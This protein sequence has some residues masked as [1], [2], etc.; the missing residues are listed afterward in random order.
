MFC[1]Q[2]GNKL[3]DKGICPNCNNII[4]QN[5]PSINKNQKNI[6]LIMGG[7]II[8]LF[9]I[10]IFQSLFT[11]NIFK[12]DLSRTVMIY[13]VGSNL[14]SENQIATSDLAAIDPSVVDLENVKVLLYTGGTTKWHNFVSNKENAI[15][16]LKTNG[17]EK[18]KTYSKLNMGDSNTLA[19]F[20]NYGYDNYKTDKYD[21]IFY[22]HGGAI[23]GAIYDDFTKDNL[24]L[25]EFKDAL[26][27]T[28]FN[29]DNKIEAI[30]F[31]TCLNGTYEVAN[32]FADYAN[33][34]I[35][36]EEVT[37]GAKGES[38]LNFLNNIKK[39]D[40]TIDYGKK[41]IA[42]YD[43][44]MQ[45]MIVPMDL[46]K[47]YSIIDLN[48]IKEL[49]TEL[50][51]FFASI[52][53]TKNYSNIVRLRANL[54][55]FGYSYYGENA[56]DMVDLYSLVEGLQSY[57]NVD[58]QKILKL[59]NKTIVYNWSSS[60]NFHGLSIYFPYRGTKSVQASFLKQYNY[61][62]VSK[63]YN[64]FIN[65]FYN[66]S[67][68][69]KVSSFVNFSNKDSVKIENK[70][71]FTMT[72]TEEQKNDYANSIYIIFNKQENGKFKVIYSSD[73]A[74][75]DNNTLKTNISDN[76]IKVVDNEGEY[77]ITAI[78]RIK[79]GMKSVSANVMLLDTENT[80]PMEL[81]GATAFFDFK[82]D[83]TPYIK[84]YIRNDQEKSSGSVIDINKYQTIDFLTS[85]YKILDSNGKYT[86]N[87]DNEGVITGIETKLN[88]LKFKR[89]TLSDSKDYYCVFKILD[90]YGNSYYSD[91][92]AIQ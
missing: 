37:N 52:D 70:N 16:E 4:N 12:R 63:S 13:M 79:D 74:T 55:Q 60:S 81:I 87:W 30:L 14:E 86:P 39:D 85:D 36:S 24:S 45:N 22:N 68:S 35:A 2:C 11:N 89:A 62:N 18:I 65:N 28:K 40:S 34:L 33:Y 5:K 80:Q 71:E 42:S 77:Y 73:N 48:N 54:F 61:F 17:F 31:R 92:M 1:S 66:N 20:I 44:Q 47:M 83:Q 49:N 43:T 9:I 82:E 57:A 29:K 56:Y 91:L 21:L 46:P 41:Y 69:N 64:Q 59:I 88:E 19:E 6:I 10:T 23:H 50:E 67:T 7:V 58:N 76:L 78:E 84:S 25:T 27:K 51:N 53:L 3:D 26:S 72:L 15:Y 32:I 38:V 8:A 75:L 90:I